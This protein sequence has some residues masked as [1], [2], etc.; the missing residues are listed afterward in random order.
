MAKKE[1]IVNPQQISG[2][3]L[4]TGAGKGIGRALAIE[5]AKRG[6]DLA[7]VDLPNSGLQNLIAY[8]NKYYRITVKSFEIDLSVAQAPK[9]I[10]QWTKDEEITVQILINNAGIGH[11]GPYLDYSYEFYEKII[12]LNIE[13]VVLLTRVF[14]PEIKQQKVGYILNVGSL[15]SFYPIP[16]KTVYSS[17]KTFMLSF[18]RALRSELKKTS[19]KVSVLCPG[20]IITSIDVIARIKQGG[21]LNRATT[22]RP[23]RL[24]KIALKALFKGR[25]IIIPGTINNILLIL[26][27]IIP[28]SLQ[29]RI[30]TK[31]FHIDK[32][33]EL[34]GDISPYKPYKNTS[35]TNLDRSEN[36]EENNVK[37]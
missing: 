27:K 3:A 32:K 8:L 28:G 14:L 30:L 19:V 25:A 11:L 20:P 1:Q 13:C 17:S 16:Y 29:Q 15:A 18:S 31:K 33:L 37:V 23:Q 22:M 6:I 10:Y 2:F 36:Y 35:P 34:N 7:L 26:N 9:K 12:R 5:C 21:F 4:I 24:A